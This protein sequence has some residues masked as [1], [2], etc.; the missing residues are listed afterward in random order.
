MSIGFAVDT[1]HK[2]IVRVELVV[3]GRRRLLPVVV[4]GVSKN[5]NKINLMH[6]SCTKDAHLEANQRVE[7]P[8]QAARTYR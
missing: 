6:H 3:F 7:V 8:I 4:A 5:L 1:G 2:V